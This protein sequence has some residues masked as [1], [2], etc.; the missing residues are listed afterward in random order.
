MKIIFA[1]ILL[2]S[3]APLAALP[4][5]DAPA[6]KPNVLLIITDDQGYGDFSTHGNTHL[7]TPHIDRLGAEGVR[8]DRFCARAAMASRTIGR[9]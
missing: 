7:Q 2:S 9:R 1:G 4:A 5:A 6:K 3:L 8:F